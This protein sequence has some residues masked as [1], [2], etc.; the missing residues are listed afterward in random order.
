MRRVTSS[1]SISA[2]SII[3]TDCSGDRTQ[4]VAQLSHSAGSDGPSAGASLM[5][6]QPAHALAEQ[7]V[8]CDGFG[9]L[10]SVLDAD[11]EDVAAARRRMASDEDH[12]HRGAPV[13]SSDPDS[14]G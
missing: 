9:A 11:V 3:T 1:S 5:V 13:A 4:I 2:I 12:A 14:R 7:Q 8:L 10:A 6:C